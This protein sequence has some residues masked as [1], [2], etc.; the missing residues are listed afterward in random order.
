[1]EQLYGFREK[2]PPNAKVRENENKCQNSAF[3]LWSIAKNFIA[4]F[5][6]FKYFYQ[7][8]QRSFKK[9]YLR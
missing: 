5:L 6:T 3:L 1:M 8:P 9:F 7:V 2:L 4:A